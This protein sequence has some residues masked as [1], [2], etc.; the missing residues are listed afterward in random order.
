MQQRQATDNGWVRACNA[1]SSMG[2]PACMW[3]PCAFA[4]W[5]SGIVQTIVYCDFFYY[6]LKSW[7]ENK[8][9]ALPA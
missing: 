9:L 5:V 3:L 2:M 8:K 4:V 7:K 6:Y 1:A